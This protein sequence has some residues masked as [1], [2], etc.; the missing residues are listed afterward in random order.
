MEY[1]RSPIMEECTHQIRCF[2][3]ERMNLEHPMSF[4]KTC[5]EPEGWRSRFLEL[6]SQVLQK[7]PSS[8]V[9]LMAQ[10]T[11]HCPADCKH[12][13][14]PLNFDIT[15]CFN[16]QVKLHR[17]VDEHEIDY[18][19]YTEQFILR[20]RVLSQ[21]KDKKTPKIEKYIGG[22]NFLC[23]ARVYHLR[24]FHFVINK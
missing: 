24:L 12:S 2:E 7:S 21:E 14:R 19:P 13:K 9:Q 18:I 17:T 8:L 15:R 23:S 10:T 5:I 1:P 3:I 22:R 16:G 20:E 11:L 4:R 6:P